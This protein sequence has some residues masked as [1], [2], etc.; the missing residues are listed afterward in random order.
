MN[1]EMDSH[2]AGIPQESLDSQNSWKKSASTLHRFLVLIKERYGAATTV[3]SLLSERGLI[4]FAVCL[5]IHDV[6]LY[7]ELKD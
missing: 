1:S 7:I 2:H 4:P 3:N 5:W 6:N